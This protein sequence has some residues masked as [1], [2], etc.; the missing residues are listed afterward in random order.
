MYNAYFDIAH[1]NLRDT[2]KFRILNIDG[3]KI[4]ETEDFLIFTIGVPSNDGHL[5][6]CLSFNDDAYESTFTQ[7]MEFFKDLGYG[8]SF[9]IRKG[10]DNGLE[11]HLMEKGYEP[12][13]NTGSSVMVTKTR[14]EDVPLPLGYKLK[15]VKSL[16]YLQDLKDVIKGAFEKEDRI[17]DVMFSSKEN[18]ISENVK[19]FLILNDKEK[20]VAAALTSITPD[21]AGIYYVATLAEERSKGLGKAITKASTNIGFD[22]GKDIVILQASPLGEYVYEKLNYEKIGVYMSYGVEVI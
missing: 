1:R 2:I 5:N 20:A 11:K 3:G 18:L 13:R 21:S 8:F 4:F 6:G 7:A 15:E 17:V 9:W 22:L 12:K 16:E 14:I 19:S 10:I